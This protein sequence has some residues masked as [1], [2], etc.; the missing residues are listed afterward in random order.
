MTNR[1]SFYF[2][3]SLLLFV[4]PFITFYNSNFYEIIFYVNDFLFLFITCLILFVSF[5]FLIKQKYFI[6]LNILY[7]SIFKYSFISHALEKL[8]FVNFFLSLTTLLFLFFFLVFFIKNKNFFKFFFTFLILS[9]VFLTSNVIIKTLRINFEKYEANKNDFIDL[10]F[11]NKRNIYY[12]MVDEMLS[13][14]NFDKI[15]KININKI[16]ENYESLDAKVVNNIS[17]TASETILNYLNILNLRETNKIDQSI[18][19]Y[20]FLVKYLFNNTK[21]SQLLTIFEKNEYEIFFIGNQWL[22]CNNLNPKNCLKFETDKKKFFNLY[23]FKNFLYL[24]PLKDFTL[25]IRQAF[26][27]NNILLISEKNAFYDNDAISK[28]I[29]NFSDLS[30]KNFSFLRII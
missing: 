29:K 16:K 14:E 15:E 24:T 5:F 23:L 26:K 8:G 9:T 17:S 28:L 3:F 18:N 7:F 13:L 2:F 12:I 27:N 20:Y 11:K 10:K 4:S 30:E 25:F 21:K 22:N 1:K 19:H 6:I